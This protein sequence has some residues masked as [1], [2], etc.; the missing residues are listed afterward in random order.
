VV[1]RLADGDPLHDGHVVVTAAAARGAPD[2][3]NAKGDQLVLAEQLGGQRGC[4]ELSQFLK[5]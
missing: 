1:R 2:V 5:R 4:V 3:G